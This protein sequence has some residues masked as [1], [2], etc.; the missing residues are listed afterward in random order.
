MFVFGAVWRHMISAVAFLGI[1]FVVSPEV[2][3][4]IS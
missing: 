3:G 1:L 2:L 4:G